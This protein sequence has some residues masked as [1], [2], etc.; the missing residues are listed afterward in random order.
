MILTYHFLIPN[1]RFSL[2]QRLIWPPTFITVV[3]VHHFRIKHPLI[4]FSMTKYNLDHAHPNGYLK[5]PPFTNTCISSTLSEYPSSSFVTFQ[6]DLVS[7][8]PVRSWLNP[9]FR[10]HHGSLI[11]AGD[12]FTEDFQAL[13]TEI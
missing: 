4:S 9:S 7:L 2:F 1:L 11:G 10:A 13:G 8:G 6:N 5:E 12:S 3:E